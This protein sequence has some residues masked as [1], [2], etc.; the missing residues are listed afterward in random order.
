MFR[1]Q[2][3]ST[4]LSQIIL[5]ILISMVFCLINIIN[6]KIGLILLAATLTIVTLLVNPFI[7]YLLL[8]A[9]LSIEGFAA[10]EGFSYPRIFGIL[11]V[12]GVVADI[13]LNRGS[14]NNDTAY[15]YFALFFLGSVFS[16]V[17]AEELNASITMAL[18]Y[19]S[20]FLLYF[21]TRYF[22]YDLRRIDIIINILFLS[23]IIAFATVQLLGLSVRD[24]QTWRISGGIGDANEFASFILVLIP[25]AFYKIMHSQTE[26]KMYYY[27]IMIIFLAL[28]ILSGSRGGL[29]ALCGMA[30]VLVYYYSYRRLKQVLLFLIILLAT[31]FFVA[32]QEYLTRAATILYPSNDPDSS[33]LSRLSF[34]HAG[35][36][37]FLDHPFI[38]VGL[39]NFKYHALDYGALKFSVAHNTFIELLAGGGLVTFVPFLLILFDAAKKL[40]VEKTHKRKMQDLTICLKAAFVAFLI[41]SFFLTAGH[42]KILWFLLAL[43]SST[44]YLRQNSSKQTNISREL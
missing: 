31:A 28:M 33:I 23:T 13:A 8:V 3:T 36:A 24:Y 6:I 9:T 34:Y 43:I 5:I 38:G 2:S 7:L 18:T 15:G 40:K 4:N 42:K 22:V 26:R 27:G 10:V 32:P 30:A 41:S 16:I 37:M 1:T 11:A 39:A 44:Y 29:L 17:A 20:L 21:C 19:V 35:L 25:L 12:A 14:I